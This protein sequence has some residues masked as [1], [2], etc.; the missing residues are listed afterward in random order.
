LGQGPACNSNSPRSHNT[1]KHDVVPESGVD[2]FG[3]RVVASWAR[4]Q[5]SV[6]A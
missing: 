4:F 2:L 5:R 1:K 6:S 3:N